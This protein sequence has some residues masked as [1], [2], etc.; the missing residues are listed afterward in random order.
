MKM[1]E[2]MIGGKGRRK[3]RIKISEK[4]TENETIEKEERIKLKR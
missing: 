1:K 4:T 2:R 3:E